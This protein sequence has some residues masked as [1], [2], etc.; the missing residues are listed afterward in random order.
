MKRFNGTAVSKGFRAVLCG[1]SLLLVIPLLAP[2]PA[3]AAPPQEAAHKLSASAVQ[4]V[5]TQ[6][7]ATLTIPEDFR[8]ATYEH[9]I[10]ELEATKKFQKVYRDGDSR[11]ESV[12][13]LVIV[14]LVPATFTAGSQKEREV[15]TVKGA[16]SIK[17]NVRFTKK[18]GTVLLEQPIEGKVRFYGE[19]LA[20]TKDFAKKVAKLAKD[21]F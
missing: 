7:S 4:V 16:T 3:D 13:D 9:V 19:N 15:T 14:T 2:L 18:D 21:N 8:V 20:A 10:L 5:R 11:A 12:P 6:S 17:I 1:A